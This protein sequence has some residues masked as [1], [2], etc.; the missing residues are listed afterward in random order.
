MRTITAPIG[1][2]FNLIEKYEHL[3]FVPENEQY[4]NSD[5]KIKDENS[6][7]IPITAAITKRSKGLKVKFSDGSEIDAATEHKIRKNDS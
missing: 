5:I 3:N 2:I 7:W 4:L 1:K 6:N